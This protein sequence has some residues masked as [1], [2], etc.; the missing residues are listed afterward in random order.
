MNLIV[1]ENI[2][3]AK[4]AFSNFGNA[5]LVDGRTLTNQNVKDADVLIVRSITKV[6][7]ELLQNS[8]VKF[9]GTATIGTDHIDLGYL[10]SIDITFADAKGCNADSVA[11]YVFTALL[12]VASE[13]NISL[14]G[15]TIGVVGIGNIGSRVVRYAESLGMKVLK[16]DPPLE[17]QGIGQDYVSLNE[18]L[19]ADII[20]LHVPFTLE[21]VD[22][23]FHLLNEINLKH[24]RKDA[25]I[26]NT[27]R[28]RVI[29][30][31]ALLFE[32]QKKEFKLVLDVWEN[33]PSISIG[34]LEKTKIATPHI[35]GYSLEGKVNGT[36][37][38]YDSL[39]KFT[40]T[41][42]EWTPGL[43]VI[44]RRELELSDCSSDEERLYKLFSSVYDIEKDDAKLRE[45][46]NYKMNEQAGYFDLLRKTYP[47]RRE[48]SNFTALLSEKEKHLK[49]VLETF[50]F[51][52]KMI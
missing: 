2:A 33:E 44:E 23:T 30:N 41:K 26:I 16:N 32:T 12:K 27:A 43:P 28:G 49:A 6:D 21:G 29:D 1:D 31:P 7:E 34:L 17:R 36:K 39:C 38:I 50:R 19:Q 13:K 9:V 3:F 48:L 4:E 46:S 51:T 47:V 10:K 42:P 18:I 25:I 15:K 11:E 24:I 45:I 20:T 22:R 52:V 40:N 14:K 37:M 5:I 8:K 35:A